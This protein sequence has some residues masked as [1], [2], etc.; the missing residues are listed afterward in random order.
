MSPLLAGDVLAL[1]ALVERNRTRLQRW[2]PWVEDT[3][4]IAGATAFITVADR[5]RRRGTALR[6]G[7]RHDGEL[8]GIIALQ[9]I[10]YR[11]RIA[12]IGYWIDSDAEGNG[13]I[14]AAVAALCHYSMVTLGLGRVE[15]AA[16]VDNLRSRAVAERLG[17][18]FEGVLR[19][20]ERV[21]D[22]CVDHAVY[23]LIQSDP[24]PAIE[25][26]RARV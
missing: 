9:Q 2:L 1:H 12:S 6:L 15:I 14:S 4:G 10:N 5:E 16:A 18:H 24:L 26:I 13:L 8:L 25:L 17:F 7:L 11:H 21:G 3:Y 22:R 23:S 20:R 19:C